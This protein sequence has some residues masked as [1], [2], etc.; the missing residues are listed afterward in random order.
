M[1]AFVSRVLEYKNVTY[2]FL[3]EIRDYSTN[4][5]INFCILWNVDVRPH[6]LKV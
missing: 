5:I 1:T 4:S 6:E 2:Y 3:N